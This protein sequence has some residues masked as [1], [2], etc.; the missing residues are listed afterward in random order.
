MY[1][2]FKRDY[3]PYCVESAGVTP[4]VT[5]EQGEEAV[6]FW[7]WELAA[8]KENNIVSDSLASQPLHMYNIGAVRHIFKTFARCPNRQ[9]TCPTED[10]WYQLNRL[11]SFHVRV[12][13]SGNRSPLQT[14]AL[15]A[16]SFPTIHH[17]ADLV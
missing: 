12:N 5:G 10:R 6:K 3:G 13:R 1:V 8:F 7:L 2:D 9:R 14:V 15:L 4:T 17:A 16:S 11:P